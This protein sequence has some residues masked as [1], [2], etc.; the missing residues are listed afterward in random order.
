MRRFGHLLGFAQRV[1][2]TLR[3]FPAAADCGWYMFDGIQQQVCE[4]LH[5]PMVRR[6]QPIYDAHNAWFP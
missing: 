4:S 2:S 6:N 1:A 3:E 5:P